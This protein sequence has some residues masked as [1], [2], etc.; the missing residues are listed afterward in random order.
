LQC[1]LVVTVRPVGRISWGG[2]WGIVVGGGAQ[3]IFVGGGMDAEALVGSAQAVGWGV[4]K[5]DTCLVTVN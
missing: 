2:A 3:G 1:N 5:L 4:A